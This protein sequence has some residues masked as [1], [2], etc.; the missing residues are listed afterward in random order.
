MNRPDWDLAYLRHGLMVPLAAL[1]VM[2][3]LWA[4]TGTWRARLEKELATEQQTLAGLEQERRD[5]TSRQEARR[6]FATVYRELAR[7]GLVGEDQRLKWVQALRDRAG[8]LN[9]PYLRYSTAPERVLEA[10]WLVPG[11]TAPV[12][13]STMEVQVGMVHELDLFRLLDSLDHSPGFFHVRTCSLERMG[14]EMRLEPD[15][16]NL[17][18]T[19]QLDWF[20]IPRVSSVA[21]SNP[22]NGDAG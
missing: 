5:L 9:L 13:V 2:L 15:R 18:G 21:A 10:P 17:N 6:R 8:E 4:G 20:S 22:E 14:R 19:C 7:Q 16:A 1:A 12:K 11:I 3:I